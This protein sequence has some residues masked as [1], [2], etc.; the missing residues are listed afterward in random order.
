MKFSYLPVALALSAGLA[1]SAN[2]AVVFS[3]SQP[4]A[5]NQFLS[6]DLGMDFTVNTPF[7]VGQLGAYTNG[8][9]PLTVSIYEFSSTATQ[10][11]SATIDS[12]PVGGG[13]NYVFS[14]ITP[15]VLAPGN[16]QIVVDGYGSAN[17]DYNPDQGGSAAVV[18][19]SFGGA[20]AQGNAYYNYPST[21]GPADTLDVPVQSYG[22]AYGAGTFGPSVPEPASWALM[23]IGVGLVGGGLRMRRAPTTTTA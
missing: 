20:L 9:T 18:F 5:P 17:G 19:D 8:S 23:L 1:G 4:T 15:I 12:A 10:I 16:Y 3:L 11:V 6:L 22:N 7:L 21:G 14:S 13:S 2:A